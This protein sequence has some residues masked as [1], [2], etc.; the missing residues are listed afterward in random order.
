M[1]II[2]QQIHN[3][4]LGFVHMKQIFCRFVGGK[5]TVEYSKVDSSPNV[6]DNFHTETDLRCRL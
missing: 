3:N 4:L 2:Y 5:S 6:A 1:L